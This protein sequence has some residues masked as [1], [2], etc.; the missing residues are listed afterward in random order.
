MGS[1]GKEMTSFSARHVSKR[2]EGVQALGDAGLAF[3]GNTICGLV[4]ANGSGKTTFARICAGLI[5]RDGGEISFDGEPVEL[6]SPRDA[7]RL[8]IV[9]AHQNLSLIPDLPVWQNIRLGHEKRLGAIFLDDREARAGATRI[10]ESLVPG[11]IDPEAKVSTL[12]PA[13]KQMVEI[14]KA[15]SQKPKLLILDE[16]TAALKYNHVEQLFR[17]VRDLK[18]KGV[19]VIFVSH[20]LWEITS[21]CDLVVA[22]RNGETVGAVDFQKQPRDENLIVP[23][24][25][26]ENTSST[27]AS[28]TQKRSLPEDTAALELRGVSV[29]QKVRQISLAVRPGEVL[30]IGGL[31]GQGQEELIMLLAGAVR[32]RAGQMLQD[33]VEIRLRH[34]RNA[35]RRGIYLVPGDR[36]RDGLFVDHS[37]FTNVIF[38]RIPL[39]LSGFFLNIQRL[40]GIVDQVISQAKL[41]P[42]RRGMAVRT[43]SGGNQQKVVFGRWLQ[44]S[45][46]V[47]LLND[48]AK[49]I[50][51]LAKGQLY[52]LVHE[53]AAVGT[54][55]VL[56]ASSNEELIANCDRVL[57]MFEGQVVEE[58]GYDD[59]S[60]EKL[61][62]ASLRVGGAG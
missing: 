23:L 35:M 42:A 39:R 11:E 2:F 29:G 33:G 58:V 12:S 36:I 9:L 59:I 56:Y 16:P 50:D 49:G 34:P 30:G 13:H 48:P 20:R 25:T 22:F 26:G 4:G 24:V 60:D 47:L 51:I 55:V 45:P 38:P 31:N 46:R 54:S 61:V 1:R 44:F 28:R 53:L 6:H 3:D 27:G 7:R 19:S 57:I 41:T 32:A 62:T 8:G 18:D 5:R 40:F 43:L 10:L 14:A 15:I 52:R 21:L 37:V 17:T